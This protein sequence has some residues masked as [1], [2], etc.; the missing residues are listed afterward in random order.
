LGL[1][2]NLLAGRVLF[3][4]PTIGTVIQD[5]AWKS[6]DFAATSSSSHALHPLK[7]TTIFNF[8][9]CRLLD[10]HR[11]FILRRGHP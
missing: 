7:A 2:R 11:N 1:E 4:A 3:V 8:L 9:A 6:Q 10:I 5:G